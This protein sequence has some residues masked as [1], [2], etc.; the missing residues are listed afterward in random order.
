MNDGSRQFA[1]M[2][3]TKSWYSVRDHTTNLKEARL[4]AFL[5]DHVTE[6]WIDFTYRGHNFVINDQFGEYW[7]MVEDPNCAE[8]I[9]QEVAEHF[10]ELLFA[11]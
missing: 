2:P 5:C 4:T 7:F 10:A 1:E 6:A 9:L 8:E 3:A 11:M